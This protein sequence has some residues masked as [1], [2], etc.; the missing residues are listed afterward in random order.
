MM[1]EL[2]LRV[3]EQVCDVIAITRDQVVNTNHVML[4]I[5]E[6]VALLNGNQDAEINVAREK[7]D[8]TFSHL[9]GL[10]SE[11]AQWYS[12]DALADLA[13]VAQ[14]ALLLSLSQHG[15]ERYRDLARLY[16]LRFLGHEPYP[17]W[18]LHAQELWFPIQIS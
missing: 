9:G 2:E 10:S 1:D 17:D 16:A 18:A 4:L 6:M 11:A 3:A 15:G 8:Q 14:V 5:D 12:K 13:D 7:L